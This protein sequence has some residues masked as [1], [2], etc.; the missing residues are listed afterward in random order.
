MVSFKNN[1]FSIPVRMGEMKHSIQK[2]EPTK[3]IKIMVGDL[4]VPID[5][6]S[7]LSRLAQVEKDIILNFFMKAAEAEDE[8]V[9]KSNLAQALKW[10]AEY[11]HLNTA[12]HSMTKGVQD[13]AMI[14]GF[15]VQGDLYR[16]LIKKLPQDKVIEIVN[17][18]RKNGDT[19]VN[20]KES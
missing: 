5:T 11:R 4:T 14:K 1:N 15:E 10:A 12:I 13:K 9:K 20:A 7:E 19:R 3:I 8:S 2:F 16:E 18:L 17:E 6:A